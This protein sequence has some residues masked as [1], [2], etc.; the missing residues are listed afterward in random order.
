MRQLFRVL[1]RDRQGATAIEFAIVCPVMLILIMGLSELAFQGYLRSS[2]TGALQKAARD[3]TIE[4]NSSTDANTIID[5]N[6]KASINTII[7][8]VTWDV[9]TRE[10]YAHFADIGPEYFWDNNPANGVYDKNTECFLDTNSNGVWDAD[11]GA[12]GQGGA[13]AAVVY[14]MGFTYP[15]LFPIYR[16]IGWPNTVHIV[17]KTILKNQPYKYQNTPDNVLVCPKGGKTS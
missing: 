14:Q 4:G 13:N 17:A 10:S 11:P 7:K 9:T 12:A 15:R 8:N 1:R 3:S 16:I 5:N 6:V 2:L